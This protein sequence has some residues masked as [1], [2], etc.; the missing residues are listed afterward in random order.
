MGYAIQDFRDLLALARL[1]RRIAQERSYD[2]EHEL[3]L[4]TAAALEAR[5]FAQDCDA[6]G[7]PEQKPAPA[8]RAPV[9]FLV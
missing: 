6:P 7:G 4:D 8:L 3:L 1:L 2:G 9:N 5:A